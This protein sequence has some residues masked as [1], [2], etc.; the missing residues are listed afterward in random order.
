MEY[1]D[2]VEKALDEIRPYLKADGGDIELVE[3][4]DDLVVKVQLKGAC[5][6]CPMSY[7]TMKNGVEQVVKKVLPQVKSVEAIEVE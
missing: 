4:T 7:Q 3:I 2:L 5:V 6:D 1:T